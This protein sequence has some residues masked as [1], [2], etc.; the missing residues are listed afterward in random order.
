VE[1]RRAVRFSLTAQVIYRWDDQSLQN[2]ES[3]G[4]TRDISILGVFVVC[5]APPPVG[6]PVSLEIHLP[7]LEWNALQLLK[8]KTEGRV[9]R[10]T[11]SDEDSGF[12][13]SGR[14]ELHEVGSHA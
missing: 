13:A 12:A 1:Q 4:R 3:I 14:F 7:A 11:G 8:L 2:Q 5:Q 6:T 9:T 10:V